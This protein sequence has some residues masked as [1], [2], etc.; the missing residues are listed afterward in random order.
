M[1]YLLPS[2]VIRAY[3]KVAGPLEED[4]AFSY[5]DLELAINRPKEAVRDYEVYP[6]ID[7]KAAAVFVALV[8]QRPFPRKNTATAVVAI[9]AFYGLNGRFLDI[10][11]DELWDIAQLAAMY[12]TTAGQISVRFGRCSVE[13]PDG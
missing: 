1:R 3:E 7:E 10:S 8:Q 12:E 13:L 11:D 6:G 4:D 9:H 2:D 5:G